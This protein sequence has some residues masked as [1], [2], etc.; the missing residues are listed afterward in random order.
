MSPTHNNAAPKLNACEQK[1]GGGLLKPPPPDRIGLSVKFVPKKATSGGG[2]DTFLVVD[3][4]LV[5]LKLFQGV[6]FFLV[7]CDFFL[8]ALGGGEC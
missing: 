4:Y 8:W 7:D 5:W 6:I 3:A 2:W 1:I